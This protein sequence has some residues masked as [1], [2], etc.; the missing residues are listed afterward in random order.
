MVIDTFPVKISNWTELGLGNNYVRGL[1][2]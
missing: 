2:L 1:E